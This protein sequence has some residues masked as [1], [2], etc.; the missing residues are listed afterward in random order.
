VAGVPLTRVQGLLHVMML[1]ILLICVLC[2]L[3]PWIVLWLPRL[4]VPNW[5]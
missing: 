2:A 1:P 4:L 5:V 3:A